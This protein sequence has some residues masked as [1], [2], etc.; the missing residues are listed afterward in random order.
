MTHVVTYEPHICPN[1]RKSNMG[2]TVV[3]FDH[4]FCPTCW[5]GKLD[6]ELNQVA[7]DWLKSKF[8]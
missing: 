7:I 6:K 3:L 4:Y 5:Y 2:A 1:C 8:P